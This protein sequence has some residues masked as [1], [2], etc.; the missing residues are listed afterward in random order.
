MNKLFV[1]SVSDSE[2]R[3]LGED[4]AEDEMLN[5][6]PPGVFDSL[7]KGLLIGDCI[8]S[9]ITIDGTTTSMRTPCWLLER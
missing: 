9:S 6:L 4:A 3:R 5:V 7:L 2:R 1:I 8:F